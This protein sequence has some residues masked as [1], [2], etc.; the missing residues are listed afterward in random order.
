VALSH[1]REVRRAL[2]EARLPAWLKGRQRELFRPLL[3]VAAVVDADDTSAAG[4]DVH[5]R[6]LAFART[7]V[8]DVP[9]LSDPERAVLQACQELLDGQDEADLAVGDVA[10]CA[11][12]ILKRGDRDALTPRF[13]GPMLSRLLG[14]RTRRKSYGTVLRVCRAALED[15]RRRY[16]P[17]GEVHEVHSPN[18][19]G[20]K[21]QADMFT[22]GAAS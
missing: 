9:L 16:Y 22:E 3:A 20:G 10:R 17:E 18:N 21:R 7:L 1:W 14:I 2:V 11:N 19:G 5:S 8:E 12:V 13:V 15:C 6:L 4:L